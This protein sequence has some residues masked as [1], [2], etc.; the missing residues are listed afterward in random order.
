MSSVFFRHSSGS[1]FGSPTSPPNSAVGF[2]GRS[3]RM[4][5]P[6]FLIFR[7][8]GRRDPSSKSSSVSDTGSGDGSLR[9]FRVRLIL[10]GVVGVADGLRA[11][12][13]SLFPYF[14]DPKSLYDRAA[15]DAARR[16]GSTWA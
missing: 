12:S 8:G 2:G 9:T 4:E 1:S 7:C 16:R 3:A 11:L 5:S 13:T 6:R 15:A 10:L 14:V